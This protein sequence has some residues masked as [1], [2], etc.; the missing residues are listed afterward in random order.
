MHEQTHISASREAVAQRPLILR[1][2][3][4]ILIVAAGALIWWSGVLDFVSLQKLAEHRETLRGWVSENYLLAILGFMGLYAA[5]VALSLPAAAPLTL[6]GGFLFGWLAGGL[7]VVTAATIGAVIIFVLAR[8]AFAEPLARR[9]GP[10]LNKLRDG[11]QS[12][13]ISYLLF[14]RLVPAFPF[15]LVNLAPALLG[16][17]LRDFA[18]ATFVGII[19]GTFAFALTGA[20]LDSVLAAQQ[21]AYESCLAKNPAPGACSF[22]LNPAT[23]LTPELLIAFAALGIVALVPAIVKRVWRN[24]PGAA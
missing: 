23:L 1:L 16:V 10:W 20:G 11:F 5:V 14:L 6:T 7:A 12:D 3:P 13:A 21:A 18:I 15:W 2:L 8:T 9:A 4:L 17:R 19:P 24:K 22:D